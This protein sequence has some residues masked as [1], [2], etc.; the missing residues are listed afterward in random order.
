MGF[1]VAADWPYPLAQDFSWDSMIG[2]AQG[3]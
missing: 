3:V 1:H 2:S